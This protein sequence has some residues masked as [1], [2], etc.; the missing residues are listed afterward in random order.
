MWDVEL[1]NKEEKNQL[2]QLF[3]TCG[4]YGILW[5]DVQLS[6]IKY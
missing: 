2:G 6:E 4:Q 5:S 1:G 3:L